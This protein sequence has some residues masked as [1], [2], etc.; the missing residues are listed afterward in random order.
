[1]EE[2]A[3]RKRRENESYIA[4]LED[5]IKDLEKEIENKPSEWE[6]DWEENEE[7][8]GWGVDDFDWNWE[9]IEENPMTIFDVLFRMR[10]YLNFF[11]VGIPWVLYIICANLWNLY[12]NAE[13]NRDWAEGNVYLIFNT[14]FSFW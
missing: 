10:W 3:E 4:Q 9:E 12:F 2:E 14:L 13:L 11:F 5:Y 7:E 8:I 6:Y 1:M